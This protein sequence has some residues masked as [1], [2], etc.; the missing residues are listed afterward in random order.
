MPC[1]QLTRHKQQ[2]LTLVELLIAMTLGLV[3]TTVLIQLYIS[4]SQTYRINQ[5]LGAMQEDIRFAH[6]TLGNTLRMAGYAGCKRRNQTQLARIAAPG[7][8]NAAILNQFGNPIRYCSSCAATTNLIANLP[9]TG[10]AT[11]NDAIAVV[12]GRG[13]LATP[14]SL[15][16]NNINAN[17]QG[18][19]WPN[20]LPNNRVMILADCE[21]VSVF[22]ANNPITAGTNAT[23]GTVPITAGAFK[24]QYLEVMPTFGRVFY[25]ARLNDDI[26]SNLYMAEM[27]GN[28]P[29]APLKIASNVEVMRIAYGIDT[30]NDGIANYYETNQTRLA[31]NAADIV[32]IQV[33]FVIASNDNLTEQARSL[34]LNLGG[35][36]LFTTGTDR[37]MRQ[38]VTLLFDVR[39]K[40]R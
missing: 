26:S 40:L 35:H 24:P 37:R 1:N 34:T 20:P 33:S 31:G 32:N 7:V 28:G 11:N 13:D 22:L 16:G 30:D 10:V 29:L 2:G 3:I 23:I 12:G 39:N 18:A 5:A 19:N 6:F 21:N 8:T 9:L 15:A 4:N 36:Q 27:G 17:T 25:V 38:V 14:A